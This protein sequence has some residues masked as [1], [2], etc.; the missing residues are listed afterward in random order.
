M[1]EPGDE[2]QLSSGKVSRDGVGTLVTPRK[3]EKAF[4]KLCKHTLDAR[5]WRL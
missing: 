1:K 4:L 3:A 5:N 2:A